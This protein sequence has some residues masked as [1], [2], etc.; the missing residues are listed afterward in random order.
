MRGQVK[1]NTSICQ[2]KTLDIKY[3]MRDPTKKLQCV[4]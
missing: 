1:V 3:K 2:I 4:K